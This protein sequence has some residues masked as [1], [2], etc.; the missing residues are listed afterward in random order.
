MPYGPPWGAAKMAVSR[1]TR[2]GP[3]SAA[4][5]S[6]AAGGVPCIGRA[7]VSTGSSIGGGAGSAGVVVSAGGVGLASALRT[8]SRGTQPARLTRVQ[9]PR[10]PSFF[11]S[12][13]VRT[14][15]STPPLGDSRMF[16]PPGV[17]TTRS[18]PSRVVG[19][20]DLVKIQPSMT[21]SRHRPR[22]RLGSTGVPAGRETRGIPCGS[23]RS[24][25]ATEI[26]GT[27]CASTRGTHV[28]NAPT[29]QAGS[30]PGRGLDCGA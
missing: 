21:T 26:S 29:T 19:S 14:R 2:T 20:V 9:V 10:T 11:S 7:P 23:F 1:D 18:K 13:P 25:V 16:S 17:V 3:E 4:T 27:C 6:T 28:R 22:V 24:L 8:V 5:S 30:Q 12:V 15:A